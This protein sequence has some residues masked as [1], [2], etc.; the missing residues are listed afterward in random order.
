MWFLWDR[1][2]N[3]GF[4]RCRV[5][6]GGLGCWGYYFKLN[7]RGGGLGVNSMGREGYFAMIS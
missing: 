1:M 2:I 5:V 3:A 7:R 4:S 6:E